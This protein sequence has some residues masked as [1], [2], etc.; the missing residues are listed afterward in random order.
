[1]PFVKAMIVYT[2]MF[3]SAAVLGP[4]SFL[5]I[6]RPLQSRYRVLTWWARVNIW[7][8]E[9]VCGLHYEVIGAE[10]IPAE[11][12]I[13]YCKHQSAW[14]TLAL[15]QIF[16]PQTWLLKRELLWIPFF[17]WGLA[18]LGSIGIDRKS[19]SKALAK[20]IEQGSERLQQGLWLVIFP[21]GTRVPPG[22][23]RHFHKGGSILASR[24]ACPVVPVA[25][26]AGEFWPRK[27][28][29][30]IPGTIKVVIGPPIDTR[31]KKASQ[32]NRE[33]EEWMFR[34]MREISSVPVVDVPR[35]VEV[36]PGTD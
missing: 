21:E 35:A 11:N 28:I 20:L 32:I 22:E 24:C 6:F 12:G 27:T 14:E 2:I 8:L 1:M 9:K 34:T 33:A 5:M 31:G 30:K 16:P 25:H 17:G 36:S 13:I 19:G 7:F 10:N 3:G 18:M 26:N 15:Q 29:V 23:N 4:L